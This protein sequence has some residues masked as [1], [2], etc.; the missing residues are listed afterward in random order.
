MEFL[1]QLW[2]PIVVAAALV[3]VVSSIL[4]MATPLH[5]NECR[6]VTGEDALREALRKQALAPGDYGIPRPDSM[7]DM[8]SPEMMEKYREGPVA[9]LT[10]FPPGPPRMGRSLTQWFVFC[11]VV[12]AFAAYV[13]WI[14]LGANATYLARFRITGTVA[15]AGYSLSGVSESIWR[16]RPWSTTLA[17]LFGGL[18]Y[19]LATGGAFGW[20]WPTP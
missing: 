20:L 14:T 12:G 18:L 17:Y 9:L 16:G 6:K 13:G 3:F 4:H 10:V 8:C 19:A 5:K 2:L 7:K 11:L 1:T 15:F